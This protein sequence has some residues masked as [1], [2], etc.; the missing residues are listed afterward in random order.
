MSSENKTKI[1]NDKAEHKLLVSLRV[2]KG[3][4]KKTK[5]KNKEE[6]TRAPHHYFEN[7]QGR[8]IKHLAYLSSIEFQSHKIGYKDLHYVRITA[9]K[10]KD[11]D[12]TTKSLFFNIK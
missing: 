7:W 3:K 12:K 10:C 6:Y 2:Y 4:Q 8:T 11:N 1:K 9:N 5:K